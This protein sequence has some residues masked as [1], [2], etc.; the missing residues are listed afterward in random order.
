MVRLADSARWGGLGIAQRPWVLGAYCAAERFLA[1][2]R[3]GS[4]ADLGWAQAC[5]FLGRGAPALALEWGK[6]ESEGPSR[7]PGAAQPLV[8]AGEM[9]R[10][11]VQLSL[12][13]GRPCTD[14]VESAVQALRQEMKS[15]VNRELSLL[16]TRL[17]KPLF[18]CVAPAVLGLLAAGLWLGWSDSL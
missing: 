10:K 3:C 16:G 15:Q 18:L 7:P 5:A 12:L 8:R 9:V 14:R 11:S 13:E 4:P 17:L 2:L 1:L 6:R